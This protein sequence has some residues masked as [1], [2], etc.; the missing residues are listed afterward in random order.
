[1]SEQQPRKPNPNQ[2]S[3]LM[4]K[5]EALMKRAKQAG[6]RGMQQVRIALHKL[7]AK[8]KQSGRIDPVRKCEIR[9]FI[10]PRNK[11]RRLL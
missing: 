8:S 3:D 11:V 6:L 4:T 10:L 9:S 2:G 5:L 7:T 1:M